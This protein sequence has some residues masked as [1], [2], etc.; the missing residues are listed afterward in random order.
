[1]RESLVNQSKDHNLLERENRSILPAT[2]LVTAKGV[3]RL[4]E[5]FFFSYFQ[6]SSNFAVLMNDRSENRPHKFE[7]LNS[8]IN[9]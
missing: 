3:V 2:N 5:L 8:R 9:I 4:F 1:M 7:L 6:G